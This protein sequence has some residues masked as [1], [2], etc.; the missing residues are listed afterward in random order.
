MEIPVVTNTT[1]LTIHQTVRMAAVNAVETLFKRTAQPLG[2]VSW[3]SN[4]HLLNI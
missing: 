4:I 2:C 1:F 3:L